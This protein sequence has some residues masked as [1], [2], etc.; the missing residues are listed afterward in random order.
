MLD[1]LTEEARE[2]LIA[3]AILAAQEAPEPRRNE[4]VRW[5][6]GESLL[7]L[8][9]RLPLNA[10]VLNPGSHRIKAHLEAMGEQAAPVESDPFGRE[11]QE[12]IAGILRSTPGYGL[13]HGALM[14]DGQ[15]FP[16]VITHK[17]MLVNAN[18][19]RCVLEDLG[20]KYIDVVVLPR[21]ATDREI[22]DLE[23]ELQMERDV[24][25]EYTFTA[26]LLFIRELV[27]D[28]GMSAEDVGLRL[29]RSI[30]DTPKGRQ[31][32]RELIEQ[33]MRLLRL[34]NEVV[35]ASRGAIKITKF[36]DDRQEL[37]EIDQDYERER[38]RNPM[39][40]TRVRNAQLAGLIADLGYKKMR[41][42][43]EEL[44]DDYLGDSLCEQTTLGPFVKDLLGNGPARESNEGSEPSGLDLLEGLEESL[45]SDGPD[46][47]HLFATLAEVP[48]DGEILLRD[49]DG[50]EAAFS[51]S[52]VIAGLNAA[53]S[54]AID[55]K[56][57]D[58][59]AID[60]LRA[61]VVH[62]S[63][64]AQS[65]DEARSALSEVAQLDD[66]DNDGFEAAIGQVRRAIDELLLEREGP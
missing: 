27:V 36:D 53:F 64:A 56:R 28:R 34:I 11:A 48:E 61:P 51:R 26:R 47:A 22:T 20:Q 13:I 45:V 14:R 9:V 46:T 55:A 59:R 1:V 41:Q 50:N 25:Q 7:L 63:E 2:E 57:R 18:T 5:K 10:T 43:T 16:G 54:T 44:I 29:E 42:V 35:S 38:Q 8:V 62:L 60:K 15:L 66:F 19:R 4:E 33:E 65:I 58:S 24:K 6:D 49:E 39:R 17:G 32:A 52:T 12:M 23:L 37:I 3:E 31:K 40:A 30:A 21:D